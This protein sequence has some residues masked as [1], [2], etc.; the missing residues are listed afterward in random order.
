[1]T[2]RNTFWTLAFLA[3]AVFVLAG[4]LF[5]TEGQRTWALIS[6]LGL[7]GIA[8]IIALSVALSW[9]S[10]VSE[11]MYARVPRFLRRRR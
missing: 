5:D 7:I 9:L 1:M 2:R 6:T 3:A 8:V 11:R 10:G 4:A